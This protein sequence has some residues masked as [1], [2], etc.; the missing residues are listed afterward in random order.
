MT[1][2]MGALDRTLRLFIAAPALVG[3]GWSVGPASPASWLLYAFAG[4]MVLT[5]VVGFCPTYRLLGVTTVGA[6]A[7]WCRS[8]RIATHR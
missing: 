3:I 4:V 1:R 6:G 2:N 8:C 5:S 7:R